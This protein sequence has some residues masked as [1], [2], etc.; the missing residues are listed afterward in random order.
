MN[1]R[2]AMLSLLSLTAGL[3]VGGGTA[4]AQPGPSRNRYPPP[5]PPR[6][7]MRPPPRRG[8]YWQPGQ[9]RRAGG[10][11]VWVDGNWRA[12]PRPHGEWTQGQWQWSPRRREWIW[13]PAHWQ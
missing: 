11:Y 6:Q 4:V 5:P 2:Y 13:R 1:R 7:E 8:H 3:V 12:G 10:R 9:W